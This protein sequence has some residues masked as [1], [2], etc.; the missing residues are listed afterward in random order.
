ML[1]MFLVLKHKLIVFIEENHAFF[2]SFELGKKG[3]SLF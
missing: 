2:L 1:M 3:P